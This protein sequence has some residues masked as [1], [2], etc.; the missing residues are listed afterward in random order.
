VIENDEEKTIETSDSIKITS[1][2][3]K[4]DIVH[5]KSSHSRKQLKTHDCLNP[6]IIIKSL[7]EFLIFFFHCFISLNVALFSNL[8]EQ[9]ISEDDREATTIVHLSHVIIVL[10]SLSKQH[11]D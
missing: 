7:I 8:V 2:K 5:L 9:A 11:Q 3:S 10:S 4:S 1:M 6:T